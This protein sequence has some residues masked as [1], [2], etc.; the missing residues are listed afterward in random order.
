MHKKLLQ[1]HLG[2]VAPICEQ[3]NYQWKYSFAK[4][5]GRLYFCYYGCKTFEQRRSLEEHLLKEHS[6]SLHVWGIAQHL[7]RKRTIG[8]C[9]D[10]DTIQDS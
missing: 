8:K 10:N 1:R 6:D 7:L 9:E 4:I 2:A 5:D 3:Q